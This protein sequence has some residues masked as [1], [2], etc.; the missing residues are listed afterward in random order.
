MVGLQ[1]TVQGTMG[2]YDRGLLRLKRVV[3]S[4]VDYRA[5][6][7]SKRVLC[8]LSSKNGG[9]GTLSSPD[10]QGRDVR[11]ATVPTTR[12]VNQ[13]KDKQSKNVHDAG[14]TYPYVITADSGLGKIPGTK[15][16][17]EKGLM[18]ILFTCKVCETRAAKTFTKMA[19]ESGVVLV[20][21]PGCGNHHLIADRLGWFQDGSWDVTSIARK[22]G[23]E[24]CRVITNDNM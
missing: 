16:G 6:K 1:S 12:S 20:K 23:D 5:I 22:A 7:P 8:S 9:C 3:H 11:P 2:I 14:M 24:G 4:V 13:R 10:E 15:R 19:Y 21:C 17:G 18:A